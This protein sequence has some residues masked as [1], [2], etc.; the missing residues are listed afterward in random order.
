MSVASARGM[1]AWLASS[2]GGVPN[3]CAVIPDGPKSG[4]GRGLVANKHIGRNT[5]VVLVPDDAVLQAEN[6]KSAGVLREAGMDEDAGY[7]LEQE[8]LVFALLGEFLQGNQSKWS[9]YLESLPALAD[10]DALPAWTPEQRRTLRGTS[11]H[12]EYTRDLVLAPTATLPHRTAKTWRAVSDLARSV[13]RAVLPESECNR[14]ADERLY[15]LYVRCVCLVSAFSFALGDDHHAMVP[16]WDLLNHV[17][18]AA[19]VRLHH[20]AKRRC[21]EMITTRDIGRGEELINSYGD[22]S[23]AELLRRHGFFDEVACINPRGVHPHAE[24]RIDARRVVNLMCRAMAMAG[25]SRRLTHYRVRP[26]ATGLHLAS[27][28]HAQASRI[29]SWHTRVRMLVDGQ[30]LPVDGAGIPSAHAHHHHDD[31]HD[32]VDGWYVVDGTG[33]PPPQLVE[34]VRVLTLPEREFQAMCLARDNG[35]PYAALPRPDGRKDAATLRLA[36]ALT[37]LAEKSARALADDA[38]AAP[39]PEDAQSARRYAMAYALRASER[40]CFERM[41]R[42]CAPNSRAKRTRLQLASFEAWFGSGPGD[43]EGGEDGSEDGS[44]GDE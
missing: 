37:L 8:A 44:E 39:P 43:N 25:G 21:L 7:R 34:A 13:A 15:S 27:W 11:A 10:L 23:P 42:W 12:L 14:L 6:T 30:L 1:L 29:R 36:S 28:R 19:N 16:A 33:A 18:G 35:V 2:G 17:A 4:G 32:Q 41:A 26:G 20:D 38:V 9:A 3:A 24:A 22:L 31:H 5:T 40:A